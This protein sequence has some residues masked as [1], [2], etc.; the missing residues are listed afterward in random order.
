MQIF[1]QKA[2]LLEGETVWK[3]SF[4]EQRENISEACVRSYV[5]FREALWSQMNNKKVTQVQEDV[6]SKFKRL[7]N[8]GYGDW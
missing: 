5:Y 3:H 7:R 6:Q 2:L 4:T 8:S 1:F